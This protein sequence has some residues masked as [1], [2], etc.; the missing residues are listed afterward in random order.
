[1]LPGVAEWRD[2]AYRRTLGLPPLADV[3]LGVGSDWLRTREQ[4]SA[5]GIDAVTVE[6]IAGAPS[7]TPM[8]STLPIPRSAEVPEGSASPTWQRIRPRGGPMLG[9]T[10]YLS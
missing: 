4:L 10:E 2:G 6:T 5:I 1:M 8:P 9:S 7:A 3:D